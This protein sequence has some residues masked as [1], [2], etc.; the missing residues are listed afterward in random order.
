MRVLIGP[1]KDA[2]LGVVSG[3]VEQLYLVLS[4]V[5]GLVKIGKSENVSSRLYSLQTGSA[6]RLVL[7][8]VLD[9]GWLEKPLHRY[10]KD[11]RVRGEW[12]T[13]TPRIWNFIED[14]AEGRTDERVLALQSEIH[15]DPASFLVTGKPSLNQKKTESL[16][17]E[18]DSAIMRIVGCGDITHGSPQAISAA[19]QLFGLYSR[20]GS[21]VAERVKELLSE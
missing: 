15:D 9:C 1:I 19:F 16:P 6:E 11:E 13:G 4:E 21:M 14:I 5:T 3:E 12:F 10:F 2:L 7:V 17:R 8:G 20:H 18:V